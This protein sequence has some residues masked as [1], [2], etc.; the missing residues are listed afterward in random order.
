MGKHEDAFFS[1]LHRPD[2]S[3]VPASETSDPYYENQNLIPYPCVG[4][5]TAVH[6]VDGPTN[7]SR[8]FQ[9]P[10]SHSWDSKKVGDYIAE[11][12]ESSDTLG[13][14][15]E[16]DVVIIKGLPTDEAQL[17]NVPVCLGFGGI[18][19]YGFVTPQAVTNTSRISD[20]YKGNG[21]FCVVQ[22]IGG[23]R[24]QPVITNIYPHPYNTSGPTLDDGRTAFFKFNGFEV[25]LDS[26]GNLHID[27]CKA[28][29][30]TN[31]NP[32]DGS[33][34]TKKA[35]RE[36]ADV[37]EDHPPGLIII[38]N[39]SNIVIEAGTDTDQGDL[40]LRGKTTVR[41]RAQTAPVLIDTGVNTERVDVQGKHGGLRPAAREGDRVAIS[42][43]EGGDLF[44]YLEQLRQALIKTGELLATSS[45][46][47]GA[48]LNAWAISNVAPNSQ[49]GKIIEGSS[50]H[51]VGGVF[52][53]EDIGGDESGFV[54]EDGNQKDTSELLA[55]CAAETATAY[56]SNSKVSDVQDIAAEALSAL[57]E[58]AVAVQ[59]IPVYG[60][61]AATAIRVVEPQLASALMGGDTSDL[62]TILTGELQTQAGLLNQAI[63]DGD[64]QAEA[65]AQA[66]IESLTEDIQDE[67]LNLVPA[68]DPDVEFALAV[69]DAV[70][71]DYTK[72][73]ALTGGA[74]SEALKVCVDAEIA[75]GEV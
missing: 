46:A 31:I 73:D 11:L 68:P 53:A 9:S 22:F 54:D 39:N 29:D 21:D 10:L 45:Q 41:L 19:N 65:A 3:P 12:V 18:D 30:I 14:H 15:V 44:P 42:A 37:T 62:M 58:A 57:E 63:K 32:E 17:P 7:A 2:G 60:A 56:A 8:L 75:A 34:Y 38:E 55:G 28:G 64:A 6:Y 5:V 35:T 59:D 43:G 13:P 72:L 47:G 50:F 25:Y 4:I 23:D 16:C 52:A 27:G 24:T 67:A 70:A 61:A 36:V 1:T 49:E 74:F 51:H 20:I 48:F 26:S 71:G 66:Q 33:T 40:T 69:T